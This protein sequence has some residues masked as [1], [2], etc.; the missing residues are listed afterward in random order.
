LALAAAAVAVAIAIASTLQAA[1]GGWA[2]RRLVG[3][4]AA[5]D[6]ARDLTR[7]LLL[8]PAVCLTSASLSLAAIWARGVVEPADLATS[9]LTWWIGDTLGVLVMFPLVMV[10][11][12]E[13]RDVWRK[14]AWP[15]ALPMLLFFALFVAI[16]AEVSTWE[17]DQSMLE[18]RL[19]SQR[20]ADRIQEGL[21]HQQV[22]LEQLERSFATQSTPVTPE[23][24]RSLV[25]DLPRRLPSVQAV[26]WARRVTASQRREF[27]ALQ[28]EDAWSSRRCSRRTCRAS[29]S[30]SSIRRA[31]SAPR[32]TATCSTP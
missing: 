9:W 17:N 14:R 19:L 4:P 24:F 27:E 22:F 15:V 25:R 12:G 8:T 30:G 26:E 11:V 20:I 29:R 1:L 2:L 31:R 3:Y 21:G 32:R 23:S 13:P 16:F 7:F 10:V 5:F 28:Q 18:F 6:N